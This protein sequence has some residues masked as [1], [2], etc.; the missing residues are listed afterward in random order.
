MCELLCLRGL[1]FT[2]QVVGGGA[3]HNVLHATG[4]DEAK[5]GLA[6]GRAAVEAAP[7]RLERLHH[8]LGAELR[9]KCG[10]WLAV[11]FNVIETT[12]RRCAAPRHATPRHATPRRA[13]PLHAAS[14]FAVLRTELG[15]VVVWCVTRQLCRVGHY[16]APRLRVCVVLRCI[17]RCRFCVLC[18]LFA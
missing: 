9:A 15:S 13:E 7:E 14:R 4:W 2:H 18:A 1:H 16:I 10:K 8:K 17:A 12:A 3:R 6:G 5:H 11:V